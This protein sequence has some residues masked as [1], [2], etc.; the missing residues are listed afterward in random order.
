M[1]KGLLAC[2]WVDAGPDSFLEIGGM[3]GDYVVAPP[4]RPG[5]S[6]SFFKLQCNQAGEAKRFCVKLQLKKISVTADDAA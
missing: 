1:G 6:D 3:E 4:E 5:R 2:M